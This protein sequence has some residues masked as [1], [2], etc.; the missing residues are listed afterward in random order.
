MPFVHRSPRRVR[1]C[2][3]L[4]SHLT[5]I[6][7]L[8]FLSARL[9]SNLRFLRSVR[10]VAGPPI[11]EWPR[12]SV[13]VP[14]RNEVKTISQCVTS[15]LHQHY[16]DME[17][18]VL[19]D[20]SSDGTGQVL[21]A[22]THEYPR[23]TV[24][25]ADGALPAGWNGKSYACHRLAALATGDWLLFTDADTIHSPESLRRGVAQAISLDVAL[26]S[27]FPYQRTLTWSE[28]IIVSFIMDF[29]P[30]ITLDLRAVWRGS[31]RRILANGQYLLVHARSYRAAGGHGAIASA[32]IDDFAL[33]RRFRAAGYRIA[34]VDG[35]SLLECRMYRAFREVWE[36]YSKNLLGALSLSG[37]RTSRAASPLRGRLAMLTGASLFAWCYASLF[38]VPF[39][40]LLCDR[41]KRLK[42]LAGIEIGW[43]LLM[44]AL[45]GW[46]IRRSPAEMLTTPLAAWG[47][48]ALSM[49]ALYRRWRKRPVVWKGR[50]YAR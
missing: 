14:A 35:T 8:S 45:V 30:L 31:S 25:H 50:I 41:L 39:Y 18:L 26:L 28:R 23:L 22:L 32:L 38:V 15:L 27:A 36:G 40:A 17:L 4:L 1:D 44:R 16:P 47:V 11:R 33:A 10:Y 46:R 7:L 20:G 19:D 21:D 34:L 3:A 12:V 13:L 43:M 2:L 6:G 5:A 48:M 37:T 9:A 24:I 42:L 49:G 29:L